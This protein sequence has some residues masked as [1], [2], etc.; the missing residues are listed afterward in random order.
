M[1]VYLWLVYIL[2]RQIE[3]KEEKTKKIN[4]FQYCMPAILLWL[5]VVCGE[6][7]ERIFELDSRLALEMIHP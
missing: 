2:S 6:W 4:L 1:C 7:K 3:R 5:T